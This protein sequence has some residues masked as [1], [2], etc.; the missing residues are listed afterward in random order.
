MFTDCTSLYDN[1]KKDGAVPEGKWLAVAVASVKCMVSAG[2]GRDT[3]RAEYRW[4]AS[5]WQLAD[6]L[7]KTGLSNT[8][9][10]VLGS[11]VTRLHALSMQQIK[12]SKKPKAVHFIKW[13]G[14]DD[15]SFDVS[16][17]SL[18]L[19]TRFEKSQSLSLLSLFRLKS[20]VVSFHL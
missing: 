19:K 1:L 8:L 9:R 2:A 16:K 15:S 3:R 11:S 10:F 17:T 18:P 12:R 14:Y 13:D 4:T 5:R 7:T 20:K 6:G